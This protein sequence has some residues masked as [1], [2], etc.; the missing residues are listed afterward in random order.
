MSR[1]VPSGALFTQLHTTTRARAK[2]GDPDRTDRE[3]LPMEIVR[4][5][6]LPMPLVD[7]YLV[8]YFPMEGAHGNHFRHAVTEFRVSNVVDIRASPAFWGRG[9]SHDFVERHLVRGGVG[10]H[11][12]PEAAPFGSMT[13]GN[14]DLRSYRVAIESSGRVREEVARLLGR[15]P[16]MVVGWGGGSEA[17]EV[18]GFISFLAATWEEARFC[19]WNGG[20]IAGR[21][22][23]VGRE[24]THF[25]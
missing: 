23:D 21:H 16:L 5:A 18:N 3:L 1:G 22:I 17:F 8:V 9:F 10:Y 19:N 11:H 7:H 14:D 13:S 25:R 6:M 12:L 15:G 4:Q 24:K 20:A 2:D